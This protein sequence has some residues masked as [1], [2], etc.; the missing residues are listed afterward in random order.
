M[1]LKKLER[2]ENKQIIQFIEKV[3]SPEDGFSLSETPIEDMKKFLEDRYNDSLGINLKPNRVPQTIY[4][5]IE[6]EEVVGVIKIR[7][8]LTPFLLKLGGN[9]GYCI[10]KEHRR[11]G[12]GKKMLSLGLEKTK[13]MGME[14]VLIT[15][16]TDN[17][18]S[19]GVILGNGGILENIIEGHK[20]FWI[21]L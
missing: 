8:S 21:K 15:C 20:R 9:I 12:Y 11:K 10:A 3:Q 19:E 16:N 1:Y 18:G 13:N 6:N 7:E 14:K 5:A 17:Q 4:F 2:N